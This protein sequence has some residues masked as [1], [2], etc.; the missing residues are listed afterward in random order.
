MKIVLWSALCG[1]CILAGQ[2]MV[3]TVA[4]LLLMGCVHT[5]SEPNYDYDGGTER[6]ESL[7]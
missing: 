3:G 1:L 6:K 4:F 7:V 2:V 5:R